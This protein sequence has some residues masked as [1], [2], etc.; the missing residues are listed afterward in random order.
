MTRDD[1]WRSFAVVPAA[2]RS[3]RMGKPKLLLPWRGRTVIEH[4]LDAWLAGGVTHTLVVVRPDDEPLASVVRRSQAT[5]VEPAAAP[6]EMKDSIRIALDDIAIHYQPTAADAWLLAPADMPW[7]SPNVIR[8]LLATHQP[9]A[10]AILIPVHG[11][12]RGH[13]VLFPWP[14]ASDVQNLSAHEGVN[15]LKQRHGWTPVPVA[16]ELILADL[17][18]PED[19]EKRRD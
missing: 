9:D 12:T 10:P 3:E 4:T 13:P 6:P 16:D 7:L 19:Y 5:V 14:L 11:S 8:Q 1:A 17:D 18:T 15:V 2:G